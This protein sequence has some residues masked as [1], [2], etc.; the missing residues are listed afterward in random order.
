MATIEE[1]ASGR[2]LPV[3]KEVFLMLTSSDESLAGSPTVQAFLEKIRPSEP[4]VITATEAARVIRAAARCAVGERACFKLLPRA[5]FSETIFLDELADAMVEAGKARRVTREEA[6]ATLDTYQHNPKLLSKVSG[7]PLKLCCT[8]HDTCLD[9]N[10]ERRGLAC[11]QRG[12][13]DGAGS[14]KK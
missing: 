2:L 13:S 9:W 3:V 14:V 5:A 6:V 8:S 4:T 7:R 10:M 12:A 11:V 1:Y